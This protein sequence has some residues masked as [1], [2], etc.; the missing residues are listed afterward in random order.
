MAGLS[1]A[2]AAASVGE[3]RQASR[4]DMRLLPVAIAAWAVSTAAA[5]LPTIAAM[6]A[7]S[8][9]VVCAV[10]VLLVLS[11]PGWEVRIARGWLAIAAVAAA[12][13]GAAAVHVAVAQPAREAAVSAVD[14][15][16]VEVTGVVTTKVQLRGDDVMFSLTT[17]L[18]DEAGSGALRVA[19]PVRVF[20]PTDASSGGRLDLGSRVTVAGRADAANGSAEVAVV[21]AASIAVERE[22]PHV[23]GAVSG[24][25][26]TFARLAAEL[27]GQGGELLPGLS[28]GDTRFVSGDLDEAMKASSLS[29]L[30]AVSGDITWIKG[31]STYA[32]CTRVA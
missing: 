3:S 27:P 11:K 26:D 2:G 17:E 20:A 32:H 29:H 18:I 25:R 19:V 16:H 31:E 28:V 22:P 14:A 6:L 30:T 5:V 13:A 9:A 8:L 7:L 4:T 23:L 10:L 12:V 1:S 21:Y 15:G 24:M